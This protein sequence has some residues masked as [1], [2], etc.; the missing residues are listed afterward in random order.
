MRKIPKLLAEGTS[1]KVYDMGDGTVIKVANKDWGRCGIRSN[2]EEIKC[3]YDYLEHIEKNDRILNLGEII[4]FHPEGY[5]L[6]MKKYNN[7]ITKEVLNKFADIIDNTI[8]VL[9]ANACNLCRDGNDFVLVDYE[10]INWT[11]FSKKE[12]PYFKQY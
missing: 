4:D 1:R 7:E 11:W 10:G 9:D 5:W 3:Y 12:N 2:L 8:L 6:R